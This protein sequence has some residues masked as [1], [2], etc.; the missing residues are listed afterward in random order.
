MSS[1][2]QQTPQER[3]QLP[4]G[5]GPE[6]EAKAEEEEGTSQGVLK[7]SASSPREETALGAGHKEREKKNPQV[8]WKKDLTGNG[9]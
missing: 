2:A 1:S 6:L 4:P 7:H 3:K 9:T 5:R 8:F